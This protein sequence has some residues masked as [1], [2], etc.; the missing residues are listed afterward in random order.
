VKLTDETAHVLA[1]FLT[2][3]PEDVENLKMLVGV[4]AA[5]SFEVGYQAALT[6]YAIIQTN[7]VTAAQA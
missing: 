2:T 6:D 4:I 7:Q 1:A 5:E 3:H